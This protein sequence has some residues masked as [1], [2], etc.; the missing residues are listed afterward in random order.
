VAVD[1]LAVHPQR[2][3]AALAKARAV[4]F[5]VELCPTGSVARLIRD[6]PGKTRVIERE[7]L[8]LP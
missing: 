1:G 2:A 5:P 7:D 6:E 8:I 4:I 3:S